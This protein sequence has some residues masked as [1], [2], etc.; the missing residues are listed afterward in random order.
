MSRAYQ[1]HMWLPLRAGDRRLQRFVAAACDWIG[2]AKDAEE[3]LA[4]PPQRLPCLAVRNRRGI[5]WRHRHERRKLSC[6]SK[7]GIAGEGRVVRRHYLIA[8]RRNCS[9]LYDLAH[10]ELRHLLRRL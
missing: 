2:V 3:W 8:Q 1:L 6:A 9:T 5:V 4:P 10:I 7:I